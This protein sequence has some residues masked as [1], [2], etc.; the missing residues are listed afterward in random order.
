MKN[1]G[2]TLVELLAV[3]ILIGLIA[4]ITIPK[5][6]DSLDD[7]KK[8]LA[9]TS[10]LSYSKQI[11]RFILDKT[12]D[13]D[14]ISLD[15]DYNIDSTG[16]IYNEENEYTLDYTGETPTGGTLTFIENELQSACITINNYAVTIVNGTVTNTEKGECVYESVEES[17]IAIA[18]NYANSVKSKKGN[19]TK[20]F[21][22][23]I[24]GVPNNK[25]KTGWLYLVEG[26]IDSYSL[27]IGAYI[28]TLSNENTTITKGENP[29]APPLPQYGYKTF[30]T[31]NKVG[32]EITIGT[33]G[34]DT[35]GKNVYLKY[36]LT[37]GV[38]TNGTIPEACMYSDTLE[39]ELCLK[40]D[41]YA[42]SE[43]K[44]KDY[45]GYNSNTWIYDS[46]TE[47]WTDPF[48]NAK[49]WFSQNEFD[50][51]M[52]CWDSGAL[53]SAGE[54]G[55]ISMNSYNSTIESENFS[56]DL[57]WYGSAECYYLEYDEANY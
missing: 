30:D 33:S 54:S 17:I 7:S 22:V 21:N 1:K 29:V 41:E 18:Q 44:I 16:K 49:C 37:N 8:E 12:I 34:Y 45:F 28:V 32:T 3:I 19:V 53:A 5:I 35:T 13:K 14:D 48:T 15:G 36:E 10:A 43:Q 38:V 47:N 52:G 42:T 55:W 25:V 31:E 46:E 23:P 39:E 51:R 4:V 40:H 11:D 2:F 57:Q 9:Q 26:E 27:K 20:S 56:C 6:K 24:S 50:S